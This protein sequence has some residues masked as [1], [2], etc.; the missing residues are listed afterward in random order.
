MR[1]DALGIYRNA[2]MAP[3]HF[4]MLHSESEKQMENAIICRMLNPDCWQ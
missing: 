1:L 4:C 2:Q 3:R